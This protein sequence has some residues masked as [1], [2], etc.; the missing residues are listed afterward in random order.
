[1][2]S[3]ALGLV[4]SIYIPSSRPYIS[5]IPWPRRHT[6]TSL[7]GMP[8]ASGKCKC[9]AFQAC[10]NCKIEAAIPISAAHPRCNCSWLH[11]NELTDNYTTGHKFKFEIKVIQLIIKLTFSSNKTTNLNHFY[12]PSILVSYFL[13]RISECNNFSTIWDLF[14]KIWCMI[15]C[16]IWCM[17][18]W[19]MYDLQSKRSCTNIYFNL[20][21]VLPNLQFSL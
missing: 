13:K 2:G 5:H 20:L 7:K 19:M 1:L 6:Y 9:G 4:L 17:I 11:S 10:W 15:W 21:S 8:A 12:N 14:F 16:I 3:E 18:W